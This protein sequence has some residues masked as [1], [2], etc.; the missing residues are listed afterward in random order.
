MVIELFYLKKPLCKG[1][2]V[3]I[4]GKYLEICKNL[5]TFAPLL[6]KALDL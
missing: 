3:I 2:K 1:I 6:S 5:L 4:F